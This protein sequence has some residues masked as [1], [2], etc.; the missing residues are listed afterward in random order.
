MIRLKVKRKLCEILYNM[1]KNK[2]LFIGL[3]PALQRT[4]KSSIAVASPP[5]IFNPGTSPTPSVITRLIQPPPQNSPQRIGP[6]G[7][8]QIA[9]NNM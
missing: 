2:I 4:G 7:K 8:L 5:Q 3:P 6:Y 9:P 1:C